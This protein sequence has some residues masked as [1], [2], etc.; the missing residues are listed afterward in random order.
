MLGLFGN[1]MVCLVIHRSRRLQSTTNSFVVSLACA[2]LLLNLAVM[3]M[4]MVDVAL[5]Q[6]PLGSV[7]CK[8]TRFVQWYSPSVAMFVL[9][10][11]CVDRFYSIIHPLSFKIT[12][13]R[14]KRMILASWTSCFIISSPCFY[15]YDT[16]TATDAG[17]AQCK[18]YITE[19]TTA[20]FYV[21]FLSGLVFFAPIIIDVVGY[22]RIFKFIWRAGVGGRSFQRTMNPVP[23]NKVKMVKMMM[24]VTLSNAV[25][26]APYVIVQLWHFTYARSEPGSHWNIYTIALWTLLLT[27]IS[28]P[29]AYLCF[30]SNFRRGCKEVFCMSTMKCYRSYAYTITTASKLGKTNHVGIVNEPVSIGDDLLTQRHTTAS[31][32]FD[33][34][35]VNEKGI[36]AGQNSMPSTYL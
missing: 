18:T 4:L 27:S 21:S 33:R 9:S 5:G 11:I 31:P 29:G 20:F 30:N 32:Y 22:T 24:V 6:W 7:V 25:C 2:D 8:L 13:G 3:P 23:R 16:V 26:Y 34:A 19:N 15:L 36:W 35:L 14:A 1:I 17:P 12:R 10:C 28:K